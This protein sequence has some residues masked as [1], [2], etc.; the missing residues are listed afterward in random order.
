[1]PTKGLRYRQTQITKISYN[2][3]TGRMDP[4][5]QK[6]YATTDWTN[7]G[8]F[9]SSDTRSGG[10]LEGFGIKILSY[11]NKIHFFEYN[12]RYKNFDDNKYTEIQK[13]KII[14]IIL[15]EGEQD[16][17]LHRRG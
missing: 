6:T 17:G 11:D 4:P 12:D 8:G 13:E 1:M 5:L 7:I 9:N 14:E 10:I 2:K 16:T 15:G 3:D